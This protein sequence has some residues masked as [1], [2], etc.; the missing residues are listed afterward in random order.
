MYSKPSASNEPSRAASVSS[1][2]KPISQNLDVTQTSDRGIPL[3]RIAEPTAASLSYSEAVSLQVA[4]REQGK[5]KQ[6]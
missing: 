4:R 3:S 6:H 5:N 2:G 1:N